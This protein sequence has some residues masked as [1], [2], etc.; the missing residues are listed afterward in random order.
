M[1]SAKE[2]LEASKVSPIDKVKTHLTSD[3]VKGCSGQWLQCAKEVLLL[4]GIETFQLV[5]SIKDLLIHG[6]GKNRNLIL[7]EP[8]NCAKT[9][10]LKPLKLIF[11]DIIFKNPASNKHAWVGSEKSKVFCSMT[12]ELPDLIPYHDMLLFLESKTVKL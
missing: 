8:A 12:L 6:I 5:T 2:K 11:S 10:M 4:H 1:E 7:T 3:C 9:F